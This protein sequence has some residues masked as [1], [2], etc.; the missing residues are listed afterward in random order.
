MTLVLDIASSM[1]FWRQRYPLHRKPIAA[2]TLMPRAAAYA[3]S[4]VWRLAPS[5]INETFLAPLNGVLHVLIFDRSQRR[6]SHTYITHEW[7][8]P[9]PEASFYELEKDVLIMSPC[10]IFLMAACILPTSKLIALGDELCGIYSFDSRQERGFRVRTTPLVSVAELAEYLQRA[11]GCRGRPSAIAALRHVVNGSASPMETFD[12][13][14]MCLPYKLGGY[15]I[16]PFIMNAEVPLTARA[17]HIANRASC[18]LD[19]GYFKPKLDIE[20]HG[21]HDHS[22]PE[23]VMSDRARVSAL[24]EMGFEVVELTYPQVEDLLTFEIIIERIAR[25]RGKRI[26]EEKLGETPER[27][28]LR[29]DVLAW[30]RSSG[31]IR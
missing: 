31:K 21:R 20:H 12:E 22:T 25:M 29:E 4:D 3:E 11:Q 13:M 16:P 17:Q 30:N 1:E 2:P 14:C 18:R 19:M 6:R 24:K 27:L 7:T 26:R 5:W 9:I 23:E 8:G 10:F 15:G 28:Q